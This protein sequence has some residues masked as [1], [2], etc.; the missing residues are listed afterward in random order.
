MSV[1]QKKIIWPL[2]AALIFALAGLVFA[3]GRVGQGSDSAHARTDA[4]SDR[5]SVDSEGA[6]AIAARTT[7]P[8]EREAT[9]L[10]QGPP[11]RG[12]VQNVRFTLY[13]A[14]IYPR[15]TRIKKGLVAIA[16]EDRTGQTAGLMIQRE[17]GGVAI[18]QV[19]RFA[20]HWRGRG[21][22]RLEP[23]RYRV[24][25]ATHPANRAVLVVEP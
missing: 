20:N 17:N 5:V 18:G 16:I 13:D 25:D 24:F 7:A 4:G 12:P 22:F 14:G 11:T 10:P 3:A 23:G 6:S 2:I 21:Q 1:S 9:V 8:L 19:L 15:E